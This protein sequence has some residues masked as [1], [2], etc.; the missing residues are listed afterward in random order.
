MNSFNFFR[1]RSHSSN[2]SR[3]ARSSFCKSNYVKSLRYEPLEPRLAL[4][5]EN[6]IDFTAMPAG[7]LTGKIVYTSGGHGWEYL[8]SWT[9][10]RGDVNEIAEA[11]GNQDQMTFY[12]DYMLRAGATVVPMRPVGHQFNEVVLDN[13]SVG[14]TFSGSWSDSTA[15]VYYDEDYGAVADTVS[16]RFASISATETATAT[17]T[18]DIPQEGF[19]PVYTWVADSSNRTNQLYT[20]N[21][22]D[23]GVT[24][25]RVDHRMV[26]KGWVY[27]G[28][29]HFEEGTGG[30]V[31]I[32]N[33]ATDGG[34]VVVADA[35]RFGNGMGDLKSGPNGV[36]HSSGT[37]SGQPREDESSLLWVWRGMGQGNNPASV[38]GTSNVSAPHLMAEHMNADTNPFGTS[39]YIGFHSNASAL[40]TARGALGLINSSFS[41]ATPN[42]AELALYTGRQ[43][44]Q[45]MQ[46]L[47]GQFEHN[48]SSRTTH[49]LSSGFGEIDG[50][51]GAEMDMTIIE[52]GFHDNTEDAELMRDPKVREQLARS[53]YEA[54]VEYFANFGGL[55]DTTSVPSSPVGVRA[56]TDAEGNITVSWTPGVIGVQGGTPTSYRVYAS[57]N[58][59]GYAGYVEVAGGGAGSYTFNA[60]DLDDETYYFKVVA[61]NS[62]GESPRSAV[63]A[64]SKQDGTGQKIL[65]VDGF[66]RNSRQQN[67]RYPFS[68]PNL[69]DRVRTRY[70]N[71]FDYVIQ[72]GEALGAANASIDTAQ[73]E[74]IISGAVN[75]SNYDVVIWFS[76]EE[77]TADETFNSVEQTLVT[78]YLNQGGRLMVS[79]SEIAWDLRNE[80]SFLND[81]LR[82]Q[83]LTDDANSYNVTGATGSIFDGLSFSF[84]NGSNLYDVDLPDVIS[85][86]AGATTALNYS[87]GTT[88]GI[89]YDGG[90]SGPRV[91]MLAFPFET[92]T[93][94]ALRGQVMARVLDFFAQGAELSDFEIIIDNDFGAPTYTETSPWTTSPSPGYN[95]STFK[96][97]QAG[98]N[99][100]ATW[101]F[102]SPFA[103]EGEV[104]VQYRAATNRTSSTVY[105][106]DTGN[107]VEQVIIN[108]KLNDLTWVSLGTFDFALGNHSITIDAGAST[109]G[110]VVIADAV[111][112]FIP[113][114]TAETTGDF[115]QDGDVDGRDFLAWQRGAG[116]P[117]PTLADGDANGDGVV[118]S[119]DLEVWQNEYGNAPISAGV[120]SFTGSDAESVTG[121]SVEQEFDGSSSLGVIPPFILP[122]AAS[123]E[124]QSSDLLTELITLELLAADQPTSEFLTST[125]LE[126]PEL[127]SDTSS[128]SDP[129]TDLL[130]FDEVYTQLGHS[131]S[132]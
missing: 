130:E 128:A 97:V 82:A 3:A 45:D 34:S 31:V 115:D 53:T 13:D 102:Y 4:A 33:Q 35:I 66:D 109:G 18:P 23:G 59:Y 9:T 29:Y 110:S 108:Q 27:L 85:P 12:A 1:K 83:Y 65:I 125:S 79:G 51:P 43:I 88:A 60:A 41:E 114:P 57:N 25:I 91:V 58:G 80:A 38:V 19:Y 61:V 10:N 39:V 122:A 46:A 106:I 54:T 40:G 56:I 32:S 73:N 76:G 64:A 119:A 77:S 132:K 86:S 62:G 113:L 98:S 117:D 55:A 50:G 24:E 69:T 5:A 129:S 36:G 15:S 118:D 131:L 6:L 44:N 7:S 30:S 42:Q 87:T 81:Q 123:S 107:G 93:S 75:L 2:K 121:S 104:F 37:I 127:L 100:T 22:S 28:T 78:N 16:Y 68:P 17:Y 72:Y 126:Y 92:I 96:F 95:G 63:T 89:Q 48:W 111:R 11:F 101:N 99:A 120:A 124:K 112:V 71:S 90:E 94:E 116:V 84:D 67:E 47:D 70:N 14:V 105:Q 20:I 74:S 21:D 103:G 8:S 26:G 49:T 52:V